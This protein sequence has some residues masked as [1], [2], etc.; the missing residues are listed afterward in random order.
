MSKKVAKSICF[1]TD[2]ITFP[3]KKNR[4]AETKAQTSEFLAV[5]IPVETKKGELLFYTN[6]QRSYYYPWFFY[7]DEPETLTW[8]D[9]FENGS[10]FWD[11]GANIG[12]FSLYAALNSSINVQAFEP[13]ASSYAVLNKNIEINHLNNNIDAYCLAFC[14]DTKLDYLNMENTEAGHSMH[15]FGTTINAYDQEIKTNFRQSSI[16]FS[17][18]DFCSLFNPTFPNY[19][20][21]DVDG[22]ELEI[23]KG[24]KRLLNSESLISVMVELMGEFDSTRNKNIVNEMRSHGFHP[25]PKSYPSARNV[26]FLNESIKN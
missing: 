26:V 8:I 17:V 3:M 21:I 1:I 5:N 23:I 25:M 19:I 2:L 14:G 18:D 24:A 15:G 4:R 9:N 22:I 12:I 16:G 11:I 7:Q 13:S 20:K 6:T 10:C